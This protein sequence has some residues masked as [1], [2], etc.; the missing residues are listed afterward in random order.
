VVRSYWAT[1]FSQ[2]FEEG[3]GADRIAE[4][5][6][7]IMYREPSLP[8]SVPPLKY[9]NENPAADHF[10]ILAPDS[11]G[12]AALLPAEDVD[13]DRMD[14][15]AQ[16]LRHLKLAYRTNG[17]NKLLI[18]VYATVGNGLLKEGVVQ[19]W[20]QENDVWKLAAFQGTD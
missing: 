14:P 17:H 16:F 8:E 7:A 3:P 2:A 6:N 12:D 11:T 9:Q 20:I 1:L 19:Y 10:A 4:L 5:P 13:P 15:A 18:V